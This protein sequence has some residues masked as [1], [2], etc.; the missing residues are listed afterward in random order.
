MNPT[1]DATPMIKRVTPIIWLSVIVIL[2]KDKLSIVVITE[3][4]RRMLVA[5]LAFICFNPEYHVKTYPKRK[6]DVIRIHAMCA[7]VKALINEILLV[8]VRKIMISNEPKNILPNATILLS[9]VFSVCFE[10]IVSVLQSSVAPRINKSPVEKTKLF[11][12][13]NNKLPAKRR[14]APMIMPLFSFS[15]KNISAN[16]LTHT[17]IVL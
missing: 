7:V 1:T 17:N 8:I 4:R 13:N 16:I 2:A 9:N 14:T 6:T 15:F 11:S 5:T 12:F 3:P 10:I